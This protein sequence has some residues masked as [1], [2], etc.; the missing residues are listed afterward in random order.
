MLRNADG[1]G[2]G[3]TFPEKK[4]H[5]GVSLNAISV[6]RGWVRVQLPGKNPLRN[7]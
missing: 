5:E 4:C 7:T 3:S 6:T 1:G 2:G